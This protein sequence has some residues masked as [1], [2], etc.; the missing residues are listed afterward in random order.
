MQRLYNKINDKEEKIRN[1]IIGID[2][3]K[4]LD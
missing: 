1:K 3:H 4:K 2:K